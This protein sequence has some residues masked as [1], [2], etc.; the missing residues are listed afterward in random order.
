MARKRDFVEEIFEKRQR[1]NSLSKWGYISLLSLEKS[2]SKI[3]EVDEDWLNYVPVRIVTILEVF[4]QEVVK[5]LVD[6]GEPYSTN[7]FK[8]IEVNRF[9]SNLLKAL[10]GQK[11]TVGE[12]TAHLLSLNRIEEIIAL[13]D[14]L[15]DVPFKERISIIS[16]RWK[17]EIKK[18]APVPIIDD[19]ERNIRTLE[20]LVRIRHTIVHEL[21]D[22]TISSESASRYISEAYKFLVAT[23]ELVTETLYPNAPLTQTDMN[24][25]ASE[26]YSKERAKLRSFIAQLAKDM[27]N[28][29]VDV[30]RIRRLFSV[31]QLWEN[32]V[33]EMAEFESESA[34]GGTMQSQLYSM[35]ASRLNSMFLKYLEKA[36]AL[37]NRDMM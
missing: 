7:I 8:V 36:Y 14:R 24:I 10:H 35:S 31:A 27:R 2:I 17:T 20:E 32:L 12:L 6:N 19:I 4:F 21:T 22:I 16:D 30:D 26:D 9:D 29:Y 5:E 34:K 25:E 11:I 15:M 1:A 28:R 13:M 18:E 37:D 3:H 23:N 33:A